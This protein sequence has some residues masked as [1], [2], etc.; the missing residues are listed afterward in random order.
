VILEPQ[1][2]NDLVELWSPLILYEWVLL[3]IE[4]TEVIKA[5][6]VEH[7]IVYLNLFQIY[8]RDKVMDRG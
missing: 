1:S 6:D 4:S 3:G 5:R 8:T 7:I 2:D